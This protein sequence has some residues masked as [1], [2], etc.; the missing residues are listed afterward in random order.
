MIWREALP[1]GVVGL[2][3]IVVDWA[4]FVALTALGCP[5]LLGNVL[6]RI[7]GASVGFVANARFTFRHRRTEPLD[8]SAFVRFGTLWV[9]TTALSSAAMWWVDS[10]WGLGRAWVLK[11]MI[12]AALAGASFFVSRH[13]VY[14]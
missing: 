5:V 2:V 14:R 4:A 6:A 12:D 7:S 11:P 10:G 8:R 13:W 1:F 9:V 3:Q